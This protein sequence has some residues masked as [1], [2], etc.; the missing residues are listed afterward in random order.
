MSSSGTTSG[1]GG[2]GYGVGGYGGQ[3]APGLGA[4]GYAAGGMNIGSTGT[5]LHKMIEGI[6][7]LD[8]IGQSV[9][10][11]SI[12]VEKYVREITITVR[13]MM[14]AIGIMFEQE[15][16]RIMAMVTANGGGGGGGQRQEKHT[17]GVMEHRVIQGLRAVNGDKT[18]FRQWHMKFVTAMG[19]VKKST[20]R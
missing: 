13:N 5:C 14:S 7:H 20:R 19:Q 15:P 1:L 18:M 11:D 4:T 12:N 3:N 2:G 10:G 17:N 16:M 9:E 6:S 8:K